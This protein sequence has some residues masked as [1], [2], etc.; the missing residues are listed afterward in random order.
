MTRA[1]MGYREEE[2]N[3]RPEDRTREEYDDYSSQQRAGNYPDYRYQDQYYQERR[4]LRS[5]WDEDRFYGTRAARSHLLCRDIMTRD[6]TVCSKSTL[7]REIAQR[8]RSEDIGA[9]LVV[10]ENGV[11]E[12]IVTDRDLVVKG[13]TSRK[14]DAELTAED[15]MSS[16]PYTVHPNDRVVD[17]INEM[18][19]HQVRRIPVV[20]RR[21]R[22]VGI[23]SMGDV[24][25]RADLDP[26]LRHT[27]E[28]I[29]ERST[30]LNR[31]LGLFR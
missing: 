26:E 28:K 30:L 6:I 27:L 15:C 17:A 25:L 3:L 19:S 4:P 2:R 11:L 12:G 29:S 20:D 9:L 8:M 18:G 10:G 7:I 13:L 22:L 5:R 23:I 16:D 1:R 21:D 31:L 14:E 24:A